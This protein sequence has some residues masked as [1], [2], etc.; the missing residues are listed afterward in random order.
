MTARQAALGE[1]LTLADRNMSVNPSAVYPMMGVRSFGR[2]AFAASDLNGAETSY[3]VLRQI[4]QRDVVYPKLMAWEGAFAVVPERLADRWVS[5]EF[6]VFEADS[7]V[8]DIRYLA[9]LVAWEGFRGGLLNGSSGTNAIRRRLQPSTFLTYAIPLPCLAEQRRIAAHL[10]ATEHV[11][12]VCNASSVAQ[13]QHLTAL[14]A[15]N[16]GGMEL[17]LGD[18]VEAVSRP[19]GVDASKT[20]RM[21]GVRWYGSGLFQREIKSGKELAAKTVY[22]VEPGDLVYNRLFAWK[23]S[24]ALAGHELVG[25][26]SNEF[27]TFRVNTN[28]VRPRV[29]LTLLLAAEFTQQVNDASTGS[30]PTSRNRLKEKDF[31][32]L[33]VRIP[34]SAVQATLE[35]TLIHLEQMSVLSRRS[36]SLRN[37]LLPAARNEIFSA[38]R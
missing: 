30:T 33:V 12:V 24:F 25:T 37:A 19:E 2:G 23:Q 21:L 35:K 4:K 5:P 14:L 18:V 34:D 7:E 9:H 26:V 8:V 13:S 16:W 6:C 15:R 20:Y 28:M 36:A 29:L 10:D 22:R 38:M 31:A 1:I 11:H 17:P 32:N 27:P 3:A